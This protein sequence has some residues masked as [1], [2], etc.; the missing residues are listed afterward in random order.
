MRGT[1][2]N[3]YHTLIQK[4]TLNPTSIENNKQISFYLKRIDKLNE[5]SKRLK[6]TPIFI[7]NIGSN[8]YD[9]NLY[10]YN[11]SLINHC[12][13]RKYKCIDLAKKIKPNIEYW[14]DDQHTTKKGSSVIA[15]LIF[16]D[17]KKIIAK[18]N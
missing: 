1:S 17:L 7:T 12:I 15:K 10:K 13:I 8:G 4:H 9:L 18:K 2:A 6:S 11:Q 3:A 14:Y 16:E 5:Y